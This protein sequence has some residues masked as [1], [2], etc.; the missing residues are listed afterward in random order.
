MTI[1][2][3]RRDALL[4]VSSSLLMPMAYGQV[5]S[6]G[7]DVFQ[8]GVASG[9]PDD[10]SL[11]I[12]TRV[13]GA[14]D[15]VSVN[16]QVAT[17]SEFRNVVAS[18][19]TVTSHSQDFTVKVVV[20]ELEP[21]R[22]YFYRFE[23]DGIRSPVG[24]TKTLPVGH[25]ERMVLAVA[26]CS[27]FPFGYF[28]AYEVIAN[29]PDV[30][31]VVHLGDYI[32]EYGRDDYG[33]ETGKRIGRNHLPPHEAT[34]L[35]DYR[36]RYAQYRTDPG[37]LAMHARHPLIVI[38][39]D[40]ESANN[41]WMHGAEN[42]QANEGDWSARRAA[43]L[44]AFFEWLPVRDPEE[45]GRR[46]DYWRHFKYGDLMSLITLESRHTGRSLQIEMDDHIGRLNNEDD[47]QAFI[48]SVVGAA[49]R[50]LLSSDME[51]FLADALS[52][53][54]AASRRWRVIGNQSVMG[55][56]IAP[57]L[58]DPFF[59][60]LQKEL[61]PEAAELLHD[62]KRLGN[63]GLPADLDSWNGYPGARER[64]YQIGKDAGVR[65]LLV[66]AGDSHSFW[67]NELYDDGG[68]PMGIELGTAGISSPRSLL[69]LGNEGLRRFDEANST[70]NKEVVWTE[71]RYR[72]FIRLELTHQ[73][74]RADFV[75]VT[76]VETRNYDTKVVRSVA[77][78]SIDGALGYA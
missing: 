61:D 57:Q 7:S 68:D 59:D 34:T 1:K 8:H 28:N 65:D 46:E 32:Y 47:A 41:P 67:Q 58:D 12:W 4:G 11:V 45:G 26:S 72:G 76:D 63:L 43:S 60:S 25:V 78:S 22:P 10:T 19:S 62:L 17:E 56:R 42:H 13:S 52:E 29:D 54:A 21:G 30:D 2:I 69:D 14:I 27:N 39:D 16:W 48:E 55:R 9:D 51:Q 18:G 5:Q 38:W 3:T 70:G 49:D 71:G 53:S 74:A 50:N 35:T 75:T 24:R 64:F 33:G 20:D 36:E 6:I 40:H 37:S 44:Q 73:D 66:L 31:L 23:A 77:I 15:A